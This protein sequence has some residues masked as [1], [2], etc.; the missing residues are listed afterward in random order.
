MN[1]SYRAIF[2]VRQA[3]RLVYA[4]SAGSVSGGMTGLTLLLT[5]QR[6]TGSYADG[7][8]GVSMCA[9]AA[10][11][12]A[13]LRGRLVDQRG[14]RRWLLGLAS[15][16][17]ASLIAIDLGARLGG[18]LWLLLLIAGCVGA[19]TPPLF[20]SA[21]AVWPQAV[22]P[23]L[24]RRAYALTSLLNDAGQVAGPALA[25]ALFVV[26]PWVAPFVCAATGLIGA[27]FSVPTRKT[28][29]FW[30]APRPMPKLFGSPALLGLLGVSILLGCAV[31]L[32]QVAVPTVAGHWHESL[33]GGP[34]LAA[35]GLGSVFGAL[36]FGAR[37]WRRT[38]IERYLFAVLALGILLA[39]IA[40][41]GSPAMLATLLLVAGLAFGPATV[42]M[43]ESLDVLAPGSGTEALT[44]V[45]TAE[46][47]GTAFGAAAAGLL[48]SHVGTRT[49]FLFASAVLVVPV[50]LV[51]YVRCRKARMCSES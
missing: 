11:I 47:S 37:Y 12:S 41:A 36:W 35:F 34:L 43:F 10:G 25:G 42:S 23:P 48:V 26:S 49:P 5:I 15:G 44:W 14:A 16:Y 38:V 4:L 31:G 33:L 30:H 51:V 50:G 28:A 21:R 7:G 40:L 20:S 19:N 32:V 17:A 29:H 22:E 45:T 27:A 3:R 18:S 46:A 6:S 9:L 24:L 13:P 2:R 39:P 8:F 1:G